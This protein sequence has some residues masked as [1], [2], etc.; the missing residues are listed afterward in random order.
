[1][2]CWAHEQATGGGR[3]RFPHWWM[4]GIPHHQPGLLLGLEL[5]SLWW[6]TLEKKLN[7][8]GKERQH[9]SRHPNKTP[10]PLVQVTKVRSTIYIVAECRTLVFKNKVQVLMT[11]ARRKRGLAVSQLCQSNFRRPLKSHYIM[12]TSESHLCNNSENF[13]RRRHIQTGTDKKNL[14][15]GMSGSGELICQEDTKEFGLLKF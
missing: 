8:P 2:H 9:Q 3:L 12:S 7:L 13:A 1:M 14:L 15:W 11:K 6:W 10:D 4:R 5:S